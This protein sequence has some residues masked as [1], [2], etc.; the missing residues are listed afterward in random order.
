MKTTGAAQTS[1]LPLASNLQLAVRDDPF[2]ED[3]LSPLIE[4]APLPFSLHLAIF[5]EPYLQFVLEGKKTIESRFSTRRFAPYD[6]V[7]KGDVILLK[8]S[9]GPILGICQV[10]YPWFYQLEPDSWASIQKDFAEALCAQDPEFWKQRE[11]ASYATLIRIQHVKSIAPIKYVKRDR[12]GWVV[13][14]DRAK[15][16]KLNLEVI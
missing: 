13:L 6:Q 3:Y 14:Q 15:Q 12:R 9:S 5:V 10:A 16:L 1:L 8:R 11:S 2:W 7:E 4:S